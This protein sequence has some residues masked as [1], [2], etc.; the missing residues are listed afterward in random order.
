MQFGFTAKTALVGNTHHAKE[1][2]KETGVGKFLL[3]KIPNIVGTLAEGTPA[4]GIVKAL[5]GESA[6][7]SED[8]ELA[9]KN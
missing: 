4:S 2:F 7:S 3:E 5:I 1:K 6:M 9:L 8:K